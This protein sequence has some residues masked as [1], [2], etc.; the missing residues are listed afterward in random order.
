MKKTRNWIV[1]IIGLS[2]VV[3]TCKV[4]RLTNAFQRDADG[5][6]VVERN[7][8]PSTFSPAESMKRI[9]LQKGY[10][11]QLVAS[12][13]MIHEPVAIVWDGNHRM[14]VAEMNTYMQDA[15]GTD[16]MKPISQIKRL[17]D[18]DGDGSMDKATV[19]IDS[20][21]LPR[22]IL[23]L[24]D[25]LLVNETNSNHIFSYRDTNNDGVA[26]EKKMVFRND[27][28]SVANL[29]HQKSGFVWNVDNKIYVTVENLRYGWKNGQLSTDTLWESPAG[30][31]G[32]TNDDYGRV[33]LSQAGS[34]TPALAFQQ[35]PFYGKLDFRDQYNDEFQAVWPVISTSDVQGGVGRLRP[36][37]TL[38]HFTAV[39]GQS[40]YR[41]DRLPADLRGDLLI[42]EPVGRLIRRAKV[43]NVDGKI[44]L[45]NAYNKE[46]FIASSDMN[47]RPVNSSTGPDGCLY[48]VDMYR[49]IIQESNW[50]RP[51]SYLRPQIVRRGLDKH[52]GRGR[53]YRVVYDGM[54]PEKNP[55][56][57]LN[58]ST[59]KLVP[60]LASNN[61]WVRDNA[62]KLMIVRNDKSV[63]PAL[64]TLA[65]TSK[66]QLARIHALWTL[67]GL[68]SL[69]RE[70]LLGALKDA[71]P[72]VRKT[73]V[74]I[75]DGSYTRQDDQLIAALTPLAADPSADVK[76]QLTLSLR[77]SKLPSAQALLKRVVSS[78]PEGSVI[79]ESNRR[80][81][82]SLEAKA[83]AVRAAALLAET[84]KKL[85]LKGEI[86]FKEL[87]ATCHGPDGKGVSIGGAEMPA[88][89]LAGSK[90]VNGSS[91]K[92]I[93]ILLHGLTGPIE[94]KTY[95]STM[96]A[97]GAN[98]DEYLASVLTFIRSNLGN[99]GSAVR[100]NDV[101]RIRQ[102]S[103]DRTTPWTMEELNKLR[104]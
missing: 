103:G 36:D 52:I 20:L 4:T 22:M 64:R 46:E 10:H 3:Y 44:Y 75:C 104:F 67:N 65:R 92:L 8:D 11:L 48:I 81:L 18:T 62:Q 53:I 102:S 83:E 25:R 42:P 93:R 91:S 59:D 17:E 85:M 54:K 58:L 15:N 97:M 1:A 87:C 88:P 29:E 82:A 23:T 78:A 39:A 32:L 27:A 34:E 41:G 21:V 66:S 72:M 13:P 60:L 63:A 26:D 76:F 24:D 74:W 5:K 61:G 86:I 89:P 56:K 77:F 95:S 73:A 80:Y 101:R 14:Y 37:S 12:E 51:G 2:T 99:K 45:K 50:T 79:A 96:V 69:D 71:D 68:E 90:D 47:F 6:I 19:F 9:Y 55:P 100:P 98:D 16:E 38:N 33:Y 49:G 35:N 31:W 43:S 40:I 84:D 57:L 28:V 7:P 94:G 30:Q 70:T